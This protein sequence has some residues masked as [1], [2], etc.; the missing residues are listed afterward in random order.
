V[1]WDLGSYEAI[2]AQLEPAAEAVV[3]RAA[4]Q[5]GE[6]VLDIGCGT[7]SAALLA[8]RRGA[9]VV[10]VDPA[11]RLLDLAVERAE[12][13]ELDARF[14]L[15]QAEKLRFDDRSFDAAVSNFGVIFAADASVAAHELARVLRPEGRAVLSA[16]L[17]EGALAEVARLRARLLAEADAAPPVDSPPRPPFAWHD[18]DAL[19]ELFGPL[20][21]SVAVQE[22]ELAFTAPSPREF[23]DSEL[24]D[25][26]VWVGAQP[27]LQARGEWEQARAE[28]LEIFGRANERPEGFQ[29][30]SRYAIATLGRAGG[31]A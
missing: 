29:I 6:L 4:P 31:L 24:G 27:L 14:V 1:D 22:H 3:E 18:P 12:D 25:H 10:G 26:P 13:D 19:A 15:G 16:W 7:G 9:Q 5:S 23:L 20:G 28:V 21:F 30:T 8:A 11:P 17:P 2:A